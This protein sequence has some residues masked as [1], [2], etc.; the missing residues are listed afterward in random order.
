[1]WS[2]FFSVTVYSQELGEYRKIKVH[3][4][5]KTP[6]L[7]LPSTS[8]GLT[9]RFISLSLAC[10]CVYVRERER[11]REKMCIWGVTVFVSEFQMTDKYMSVNYWQ[12]S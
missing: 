2:F 7:I 12:A 3:L 11:Q 1:M 10:A 5:K 4:K 9:H 6:L 8:I